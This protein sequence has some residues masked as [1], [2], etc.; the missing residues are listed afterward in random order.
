MGTH[1]STLLSLLLIGAPFSGYGAALRK[2]A[3]DE[4]VLSDPGDAYFS[5]VPHPIMIVFPR[6]TRA[7]PSPW[8]P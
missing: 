5:S 3:D 1:R 8:T 6:S 4:L 7:C 2:M